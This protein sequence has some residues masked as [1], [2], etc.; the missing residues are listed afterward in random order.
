MNEFDRKL[1]LEIFSFLGLHKFEGKAC[2]VFNDA[3]HGGF[4]QGHSVP[5]AKWMFS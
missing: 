2:Q 4:W 5:A 1:L 3:L